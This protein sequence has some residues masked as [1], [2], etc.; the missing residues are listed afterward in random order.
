MQHFYSFCISS[1]LLFVPIL[2][3]SNI[4]LYFSSFVIVLLNLSTTRFVYLLSGQIWRG[5]HC[6]CAVRPYVAG[7][8]VRSLCQIWCCGDFRK[9]LYLLI[10]CEIFLFWSETV[11]NNKVFNGSILNLLILI[12]FYKGVCTEL[13]NPVWNS[14]ASHPY[15]N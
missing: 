11:H 1:R 4:Y 2:Y 12:R 13:C 5:P 15:H 3:G 8:A 7:A 14:A 9:T 6:A 10:L